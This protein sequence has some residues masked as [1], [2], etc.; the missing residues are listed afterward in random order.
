M[1]ILCTLSNMSEQ[2]SGVRFT[3]A[4]DGKGWV[5]EDLTPALANAFAAIPG[6]SL[7]TDPEP[8]SEPTPPAKKGK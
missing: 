2:V 3:P 7:M 1:R 8:E 6:Y 4:P 5:S